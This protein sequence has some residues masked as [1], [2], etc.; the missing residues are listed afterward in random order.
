MS[1]SV[2]QSKQ[3]PVRPPVLTPFGEQLQQLLP[4]MNPVLKSQ[5]AEPV[6]VRMLVTPE[7]A[8]A[9]LEQNVHNRN[10]AQTVINKY[11]RNMMT[12]RWKYNH[13]AILFDTSGKMIDGQHRCWACV[14][15]KTPFETDVVFGTDP[16][17]QDYIDDGFSRTAGQKAALHGV[18]NANHTCAI[19]RLLLIHRNGGIQSMQNPKNDPSKAEILELAIS[20]DAQLEESASKVGQLSRDLCSPSVLGFCHYLFHLQNCAKAAAFFDEL[21]SG[22][23]LSLRNPARMLREK[24]KRNKAAKAKLPTVHLIALFFRAWVYYRD[25]KNMQLVKTWRCDGPNPEAFPEI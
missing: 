19:A 16:E 6:R 2:K 12:G 3:P 21:H 11:A 5:K 7:Q 18:S 24:F 17:V 13:Q 15:S 20:Q 8:T 1:I 14:E 9:W 22:V 10:L 25:A 23:N 4:T